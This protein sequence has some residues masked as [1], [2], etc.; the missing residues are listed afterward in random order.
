MVYQ[1]MREHR[2]IYPVREMAG[3]LGI[4]GSAYYRWAK[5]GCETWRREA[6]AEFLHLIRELVVRHYRR[7]GSP[8]VRAELRLSKE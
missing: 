5:Y 6:D 3:L 7:Y 8:R 2:G 1:F 4:S